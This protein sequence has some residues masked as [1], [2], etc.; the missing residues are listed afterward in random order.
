MMVQP[1]SPPVILASDVNVQLF[2]TSEQTSV[3]KAFIYYS[4]RKGSEKIFSP[5]SVK[6]GRTSPLSLF[7]L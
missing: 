7:A 5:E 1:I 2:S 6:D 3:G 4:K